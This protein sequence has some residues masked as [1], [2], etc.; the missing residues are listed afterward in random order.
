M[1]RRSIGFAAAFGAVA[2]T[3]GMIAWLNVVPGWAEAAGSWLGWARTGGFADWGPAN[4]GGLAAAFAGG[5]IGARRGGETRTSRLLALACGVAGAWI[6]VNVWL[7][8]GLEIR[9]WFRPGDPTAG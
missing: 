4:L 5:W 9:N 7:F 8:F 2:G 1:T 6:L 3:A